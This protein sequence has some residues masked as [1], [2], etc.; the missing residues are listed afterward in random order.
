MQQE[1]NET[2]R[3]RLIT[4]VTNRA[5]KQAELD[6]DYF[7]VQLLKMNQESDN[8][9][10]LANHT[11]DKEK[12]LELIHKWNQSRKVIQDFVD[13]NQKGMNID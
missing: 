4:D 2:I 12:R 8:L 1:T 6:G 10:H 9:Y 3:R 13:N 5:I 7:K 11:E